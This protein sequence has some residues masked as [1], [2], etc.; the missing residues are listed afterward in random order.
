MP[1]LSDEKQQERRQHILDAAGACFARKGFHQTTMSDICREAGVSA[2]AL[3]LYFKSKE[4][5]IEGLVARDRDEFLELFAEVDTSDLMNSLGA[6]MDT[7]VVHQPPE[8]I[9]IFLEIGVESRRNPAVAETMMRCDA[10]IRASI[11][12]LLERAKAAGTINPDR[13]ISEIVDVME[14]IADG[15]FWSLGCRPNVDVASV[16]RSILPVIA[17]MLRPT[18][19]APFAPSLFQSHKETSS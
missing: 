9:A 10:T 12:D 16:A 7:C 18:A 11:T 4:T 6:L 2:G 5:L 14:V 15:L 3:Y 13:P 8:K 17:Q 19:P 1:K